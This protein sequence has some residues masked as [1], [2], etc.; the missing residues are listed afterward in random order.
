MLQ[1]K[2]G[3]TSLNVVIF[4]RVL[5][6]FLENQKQWPPRPEI[7]DQIHAL[8]V[9]DCAISSKSIVGQMIISRERVRFIIHED[10]DMR[11]LSA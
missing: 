11:Q 3:W 7:I 6:I 5:R 9:E 8:I 2:T 10:L 4:P 1:S